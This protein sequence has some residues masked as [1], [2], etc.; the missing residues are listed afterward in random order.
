LPDSSAASKPMTFCSIVAALSGDDEPEPRTIER[1]RPG[2]LR[3]GVLRFRY[4]GIV[5]F[6]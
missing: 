5:S 6:W 1:T 4:T 3:I 2:S